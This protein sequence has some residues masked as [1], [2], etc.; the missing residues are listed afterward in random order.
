M[1][2]STACPC[3]QSNPQCGPHGRRGRATRPRP[4]S[5]QNPVQY[6]WSRYVRRAA[7]NTRTVLYHM[8]APSWCQVVLVDLQWQLKRT[9]TATQP[10]PDCTMQTRPSTLPRTVLSVRWS[11]TPTWLDAVPSTVPCTVPRTVPSTQYCTNLRTK[12]CAEFCTK[13]C[14]EYCTGQKQD[15]WQMHATGCAVPWQ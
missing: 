9:L 10:R 5:T 11:G 7:H 8:C 13:Y 4:N 15:C 14:T 12:Y 6:C 2:C 1:Q 3:L